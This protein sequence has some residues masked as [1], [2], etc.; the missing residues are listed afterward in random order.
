MVR[1]GLCV[2]GRNAPVLRLCPECITGEAGPW[3]R[4]A[5]WVRLSSPG[6]TH[7]APVVQGVSAM[8]P[9]VEFLSPFVINKGAVSNGFNAM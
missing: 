8:F 6:D 2:F 7:L 4:R 9:S 3:G 1:F 5:H